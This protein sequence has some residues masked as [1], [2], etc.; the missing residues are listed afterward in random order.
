MSELKVPLDFNI[1]LDYPLINSNNKRTD[2][3]LNK[4]NI[5]VC[6]SFDNTTYTNH[7]LNETFAFDSMIEIEA[8]GKPNNRIILNEIHNFISYYFPFLQINKQN[9]Y[10]RGI[11]STIEKYNNEL[12]SQK[13][14]LSKQ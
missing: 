10:E 7:F 13:L 2:I 5:E 6:L 1:I 12:N 3:I 9:K 14:T 8:I 11:N 4:N